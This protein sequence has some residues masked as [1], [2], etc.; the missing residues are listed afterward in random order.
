M[1]ALRI[2]LLVVKSNASV[3]HQNGKGS[4]K[5]ASRF[6]S[7]LFFHFLFFSLSRSFLVDGNSSAKITLSTYLDF[8][9]F[10]YIYFFMFVDRN[11]L[12]Q[13]VLLWRF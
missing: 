12:L 13:I 11:K 5:R 7:F 6:I 9:L 8:C 2:G 1:H 10:M 3:R 4:S